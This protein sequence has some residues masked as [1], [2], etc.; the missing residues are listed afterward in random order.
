MHITPNLPP[1]GAANKERGN[2]PDAFT[3]KSQLEIFQL[4]LVLFFSQNNHLYPNDA[5]KVLFA[6]SLCTEGAPVQFAK[7][8]L[9]QSTKNRGRWGTFEDFM[10]K[11]EQSFG[12]PNEERNEF[13]QLEKLKM[14]DNESADEYFQ[15]F[16]MIGNRANAFENNDRQIIYL[17]EKQVHQELIHRVYAKDNVPTTYEKYK[18]AVIAADTLERQFK[19]VAQDHHTSY[20]K[21]ASTS[22]SKKK[23]T[24]S[25]SNSKSSGEEKKKKFLF[26]RLKAAQ[27]NAQQTDKSKLKPEDKCFLCGRAGHWKKDCPN[28]KKSLQLRAQYQ[29]LT[30]AEKEE[31]AEASF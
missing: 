12:D 23:H 22:A 25:K 5:D 27:T 15:R 7:L 13:V 11:L 2:R 28:L 1:T 18:E 24:T 20:Q 30:D 3:K 4:Q 31:F 19:A 10:I 8:A 21:E 9:L 6:L 29:S 16:E 14:K 17:I 26:I